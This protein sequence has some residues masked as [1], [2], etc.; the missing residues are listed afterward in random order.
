MNVVQVKKDWDFRHQWN[1]SGAERPCPVTQ[2][3]QVS[4]VSQILFLF[5]QQ[6]VTL[7]IFVVWYV[8]TCCCVCKVSVS[9]CSLLF[10]HPHWTQ[11]LTGKALIMLRSPQIANPPWKNLD[12]P[13]TEISH[14]TCLVHVSLCFY[15]SV[16]VLV[17][18]LCVCVCVCVCVRVRVRVRAHSVTVVEC[19][20]CKLLSI[21]S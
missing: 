11:A 17:L 20:I 1:H 10:S 8:Y 14:W 18:V 5:P 16:L 6:V 19:E 7:S 2:V 21:K 12:Y 15:L 4:Y 3:Q 13:K 9:N